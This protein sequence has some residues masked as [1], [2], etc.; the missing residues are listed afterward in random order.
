MGS[1]SIVGA[2]ITAG[3]VTTLVVATG[4]AGTGVG[5]LT[6]GAGAVDVVA[7]GVAQPN[8]LTYSAATRTPRNHFDSEATLCISRP[9]KNWSAHYM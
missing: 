7:G 6:T 8:R 5:T 1:V 3:A 2:T 4:G 9:I